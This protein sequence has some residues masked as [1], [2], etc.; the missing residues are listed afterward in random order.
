MA[1]HR[2]RCRVRKISV[3]DALTLAVLAGAGMLSVR[4]G[5]VLH[6]WWDEWKSRREMHAAIRHHW[7]DLVRAASRL[8]EADVEPEVIEFIDY[9]CPFCRIYSSSVDS[10]SAAGLRVAIVQFPLPRYPTSRTAARVALCADT[11]GRFLSAHSTLLA[12]TRWHEADE[13]PTD[14]EFAELFSLSAFQECISHE[15]VEATLQMHVGLGVAL[16]VTGTPTFIARRGMLNGLPSMTALLQ[17]ARGGR[18]R[19]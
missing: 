6:T 9:Q 4:A 13:W 1:N 17:F 3:L 2:I 19:E 5:S 16:G 18:E 11:A 10:A 14:G 15:S 8:Y 7:G 12:S